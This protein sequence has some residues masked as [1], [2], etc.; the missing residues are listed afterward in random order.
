MIINVLENEHSIFD[1]DLP[2]SKDLLQINI[3]LCH[4]AGIS[5]QKNRLFSVITLLHDKQ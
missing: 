5:S 3:L 1:D 2:Q 4:A